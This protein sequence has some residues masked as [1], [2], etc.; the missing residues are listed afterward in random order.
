MELQEAE[1][2]VVGRVAAVPALK[3]EQAALLMRLEEARREQT[4]HTLGS[5]AEAAKV[6]RGLAELA[7]KVEQDKAVLEQNENDKELL[8]FFHPMLRFFLLLCFQHHF[9]STSSC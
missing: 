2:A 5:G 1:A 3:A 8:H 4:K 7:A 6:E 9:A